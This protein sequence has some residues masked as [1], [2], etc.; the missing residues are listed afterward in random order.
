LT[1]YKVRKFLIRKYIGV[2]SYLLK[3]I[4]SAGIFALNFVA[5]KIEK[6]IYPKISEN[7]E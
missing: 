3:F 5:I 6:W 1:E 4:W 7:S 2:V